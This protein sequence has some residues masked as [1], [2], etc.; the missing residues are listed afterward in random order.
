M[1]PYNFKSLQLCKIIMKLE[2]FHVKIV[3]KDYKFCHQN[4]LRR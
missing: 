3:K 1:S 2:H 4:A